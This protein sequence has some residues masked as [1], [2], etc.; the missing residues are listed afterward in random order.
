[1]NSFVFLSSTSNFLQTLPWSRR[2]WFSP[3]LY[4]NE[5]L[6]DSPIGILHNDDDNVKSRFISVEKK[7]FT[8]NNLRQALPQLQPGA[9]WFY[10]ITEKNTRKN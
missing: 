8:I 6:N 9:L 5:T 2:S 1:M 4:S 3:L 10:F 7:G